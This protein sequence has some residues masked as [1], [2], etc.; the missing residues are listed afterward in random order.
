MLIVLT[1]VL[2]LVAGSLA[3]LAARRFERRALEGPLIDLGGASAVLA[4]RPGVAEVAG[5]L[6]A[7]GLTTAAGLPLVSA[8]ILT[9]AL[10]T[11][12]TID[13][14][15]RLIPDSATAGIAVLALVTPIEGGPSLP[16]RLATAATLGCL[17]LLLHIS[18]RHLRGEDGV[19]LGDV[20]L[21]TALSLWLGPVAASLMLAGA[22]LSAVLWLTRMR[23]AGQPAEGMALAPFAVI[24]F[25]IALFVRGV[26][27]P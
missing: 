26:L 1:L 23:L 24:A 14:Q 4:G 9:F 12:A 20:K 10:I 6:I 13:A 3:R 25:L 21:L 18:Y 17:L 11:V 8:L 5:S 16:L 22:S 27:A 19:G 2:G 7:L 15:H